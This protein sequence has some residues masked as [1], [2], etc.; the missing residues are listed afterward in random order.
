[1]SG[2]CLSQWN[3]I[4]IQSPPPVTTPDTPIARALF[5]KN[6][7]KRESWTRA[8]LEQEEGTP[9]IRDI[10]FFFVFIGATVV[11]STP[12]GGIKMANRGVRETGGGCVCVL[13]EHLRTL[14]IRLQ[15]LH[16]EC[17]SPLHR[18]PSAGWWQEI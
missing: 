3:Q 2:T 16:P 6:K 17:I 5:S 1:M 14:V 13:E 10:F 18:N 7:A 8:H 9:Y 4:R 15:Q 12:L 11:G